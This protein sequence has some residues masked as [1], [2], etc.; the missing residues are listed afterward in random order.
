MH[1]STRPRQIRSTRRRREEALL[2]PAGI[3]FIRH[4]VPQALP[5]AVPNGGSRDVREGAQLKHQGVLA[6]WPDVGV[7]LPGG[8]CIWLEFKSR[9]GRLSTQQKA[10]HDHLRALGAEVAVC[11]TLEDIEAFLARF[12]DLKASTK[13]GTR[14][15]V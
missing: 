8:T 1:P 5:F 4:A 10:V 14:E 3:A 15:N 11:R 6:G 13:T 12:C 7:I 2:Q 9:K